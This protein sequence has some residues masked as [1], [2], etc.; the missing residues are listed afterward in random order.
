MAEKRD[1]YEVLGVSKGASDEEIKKAFR[2]LAKKYHPDVNPGDKEAEAKFKEVGEAYAVLSDAEKRA[3]YDQY[4]HAAF[5]PA[6]GGQSYDFSGANF[7]D[8]FGGFGDIFGDIFGFGGASSA[9]RSNGAVDGDDIGVRVNVSFEEA[10]FGCKKDVSFAR[11]EKCPDCQGSGCAKGTSAE[12]CPD[13]HGTGSVR[14]VQRTILGMMQTQSACSRC[15]GRGKIIKTPC[16]NCSGKGYIRIK[17]TLSVSIPAGIDD[18]QRVALRGQGN[19]GR[20]GGMAGD[21]IIGVNVKSHN[22]F[23]RD[24][25]DIFCEI[26]ITIPEAVLGAT[27]EVP[28]LEKDG[29]KTTFEI[30]EGTQTGSSFS[31]RALGI[32]SINGGKRGNLT[33][34]VTVETPRNLNASQ[35]ELMVKFAESCGNKNFTKKQSFIKKIFDK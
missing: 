5:D 12:T 14:T 34:T 33:F 27:I 31:I 3:K 10:A 32:P 7:S 1:Y 16:A 2:S 35:K 25:N 6:Q 11:V 18:G 19:E 20:N 13:C 29:G 30:P 8:I 22:I 26:P 15:G 17:K 4:G 9:R 24:G 21:L 23:R 28:T